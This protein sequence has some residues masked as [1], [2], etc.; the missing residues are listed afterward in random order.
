M[1]FE[2][3][4]QK[5][6]LHRVLPTAQRVVHLWCREMFSPPHNTEDSCCKWLFQKRR[7]GWHRTKYTNATGTQ[8]KIY[9]KF[10][11]RIYKIE[12]A[13][14]KACD[15]LPCPNT[16]RIPSSEHI[17]TGK[18]F[19]DEAE[20]ILEESVWPSYWTSQ[21]SLS[22]SDWPVPLRPAPES[23]IG[24]C[25]HR[26]SQANIV[27]QEPPT[28]KHSDTNGHQGSDKFSKTR[29]RVANHGM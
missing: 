27:P 21:T 28:F 11:T 17:M 29:S 2:H 10:Q 8:S 25:C 5:H 13:T 16:A 24:C 3:Q 6:W 22:E 23:M 26:R 14:H 1:D 19:V 20:L 7:G 12:I 15:S 9:I 18:T 4:C